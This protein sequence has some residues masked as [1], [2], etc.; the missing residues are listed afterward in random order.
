MV[1]IGDRQKEQDQYKGSESK[2]YGSL[3]YYRHELKVSKKKKKRMNLSTKGAEAKWE[4]NITLT[5]Y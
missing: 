5:L 1:W 3:I 2:V 4:K